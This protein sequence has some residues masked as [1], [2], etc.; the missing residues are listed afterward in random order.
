MQENVSC[1]PFDLG[2]STD[3]VRH[4]VD[5]ALHAVGMEKFADKAVHNLSFGQKKR[6]CIAGVLAMEPELLVL[7]E[8]MPGIDVITQDKFLAILDDLHP[9]GITLLLATHD[10]NFAYAWADRIHLMSSGRCI[11]SVEAQSLALGG[12][13]LTRMGL[14]LPEIVEL[15]HKLLSCGLF[16]CEKSPRSHRELLSLFESNIY[17]KKAP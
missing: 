2:L 7:D 14:P 8:P 1:G 13:I 10:I 9:R 4:R 6:A 5:A 17:E 12:E 15:E 3:V 11:A 16:S